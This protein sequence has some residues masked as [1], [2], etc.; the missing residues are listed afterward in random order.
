MKNRNAVVA[1][2]LQSNKGIT[3]IHGIYVKNKPKNKWH[4]FSVA[5][6]PEMANQ[7]LDEAKKQAL[8]EGHDAAEVAIQIF[9]TVFWIPE[10]MDQ[11]KEQK[12]LFN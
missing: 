3:M 7:E 6:S 4:L 2:L 11:I 8:L 1:T 10:Y 9:D 5:V 12:P